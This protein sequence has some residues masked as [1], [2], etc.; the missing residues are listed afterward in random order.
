MVTGLMSAIFLTILRG[1][2]LSFCY[3]RQ[4]WSLQAELVYFIVYLIEGLRDEQVD[5]ILSEHNNN[6][7]SLE[8]RQNQQYAQQDENLKVSTSLDPLKIFLSFTWNNHAN[9]GC[10]QGFCWI[11]NASS[12]INRNKKLPKIAFLGELS[13]IYFCRDFS[14]LLMWDDNF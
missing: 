8:A 6:V 12:W 11:L 3:A 10:F 2:K 9:K 13:A 4:Y 7:E 1:S 14:K 5:A